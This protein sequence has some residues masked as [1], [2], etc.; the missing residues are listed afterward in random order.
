M[1]TLEITGYKTIQYASCIEELTQ[2][3]F[4]YFVLL[5]IQQQ[6]NQITIDDFRRLLAY[7]LLGLRK[8]LKYY[9]MSHEEREVIND[10]I[11]RIVDTLDSF[12]EYTEVDKNLVKLLTM[13]WVKQMLPSIGKLVGPDDA[14][15]NCSIFEY[16]EAFTQ[17]NEYRTSHE[18]ETLDRMIAILYRPRK[19]FF[20]IRK[21]FAWHDIEERQSF[22]SK[23][24]PDILERR[25]K[26]VKHLPQ[27]I[28][29]AIYL[30]FEN[31]VQYIVSGKPTVDGVEIDFSVLFSNK[32]DGA[33]PSGIGLTGIIYS[34][35]ESSVFGTAEQT[36]NTGLYDILVRLYQIK[37][38]YDTMI[39]KTKKYDND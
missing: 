19:Y 7:K 31:C 8:S 21:R 16:K 23:T 37:T 15:T 32:N 38:D 26:I 24:N 2:D 27:Y 18:E 14:L 17:F 25:I 34:L 13:K 20:R 5:Y 22:T 29:A 4:V 11:N 3:E 39:A 9:R 6:H 28:K 36:S 35:A 10:N 12:Y 33:G 1:H 30:W